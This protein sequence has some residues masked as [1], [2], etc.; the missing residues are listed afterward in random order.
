MGLDVPDLDDRE[1]DGILEDAI[2]RISVHSDEW[3]DHNA[4]DPGITILELLAWVV[5]TD[6]YSLDRLDQRHVRKYLKLM[7]V[8]PAPPRP[9]TA[10]LRVDPPAGLDG[11]TVPAREKIAVDDGSEVPKTF[12]TASPLTL[13][14]ARLAAVVTDHRRGRID[15]TNANRTADVHFHPFGEDARRGS[16]VY[17]G[18]DADPFAAADRFELFVDFHEANLPAPSSHGDEDSLLDPSV[19]VD[20]EY[21]TDPDRWH[22]DESWTGI[23]VGRD[24]TERF[25]HSGRVTLEAP[26][27]WNG[28]PASIMDRDDALHWV[29]CTVRTP[30]YEVPPQVNAFALNAVDVTHRARVE[31][32]VELERIGDALTARSGR[33]GGRGG[34]SNASPTTTSARPGQTFAFDHVPVLEA[35]VAVGGDDWQRV[36]DFDASGPD[37]RHFVLDRERGEIRFGDNVRGSVPEAGQVVTA[38]SYEHG[39]GPDGNVP[40]AADWEFRRDAL[41]AA[42]VRTRSRAD[43]GTGAESVADALH[44]L[45][46]D[47]KTPYR[48]VSPADYRYVATH[49]PG[50]RFGRATTVLERREPVDGCAPT[51]TVRVVVVPFST[52]DRPAPSQGFLDAVERHLRSHRLV[53]DRVAVEAPTYVGVAVETAVRIRDGYSAGGRAAA[54]E[55]ALDAFLDPLEGF[56]GEGWPF[57]RPVYRSEVYEAIETVEGVECADALSIDA[58]GRSRVDEDGNVMIPDGSDGEPVALT[59]P[60]Q[61]RVTV[62]DDSDDCGGI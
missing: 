43:G 17:L 47:R 2:K 61:H 25:H 13:T 26:D 23:D 20:W 57:G 45:K 33:A 7:G 3:T 49:T 15:Q 53:T 55:D 41:A 8:E 35:T 42:T 28:E 31:G 4:H 27:D 56:D 52:R 24:D 54:V 46:R 36:A 21:C 44:R 14:T 30:G 12:E 16:A 11:T 60:E 34:G 6:L 29:R 32:P 59:Y 1:F 50:L 22:R 37:D 39:G 48:A 51:S 18:F 10:R 9:A 5:E 19:G 62:V 38:R 40:S 58:R